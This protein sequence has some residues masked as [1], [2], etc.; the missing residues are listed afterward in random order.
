MKSIFQDENMADLISMPQKETLLRKQNC[1]SQLNDKEIEILA[2]LL[3]EKNFTRGQTIVTEG[4]PVDSV[5][6]IIAGEADVRHVSIQDGQPHIESLATLKA[7]DAIGLNETGFYS[8]SGMRTATVVANTDMLLLS[9]SVAAFHGFTLSNS[10][11]NEVMRKYAQKW[12]GI[13]MQDTT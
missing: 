13:K 2:G 9:L 4:E 3:R 8:L 11:A 1:F 12:L 5:F 7:G 10:R 6:F